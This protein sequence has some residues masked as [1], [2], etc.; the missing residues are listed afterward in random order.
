MTPLHALENQI[1]AGLQR[2]VQ[3]RHQPRLVGDRVEEIGIGF[4]RVDRRQPQT[5][6]IRHVP[7][8]ALDQDAEPRSAYSP[9]R[10]S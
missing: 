1:V 3:M 5:R 7:E 9:L 4:D 8:D 6:Q 10:N 2:Q